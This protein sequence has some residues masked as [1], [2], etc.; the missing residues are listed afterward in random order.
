[1]MNCVRTPALCLLALFGVMAMAAHADFPTLEVVPPDSSVHPGQQATFIYRVSWAGDGNEWRVPA[2][3]MDQPL[4]GRTTLQSAT[5]Y[6]EGG[7]TVVDFALGI[8]AGDTG[9][10]ELPA[11]E[12]E[13][14]PSSDIIKNEKA[15][16]KEPPEPWRT[17]LILTAEPVTLEVVPD[18]GRWIPTG[19]VGGLTV[20]VMAGALWAVFRSRPEPAASQPVSDDPRDFIHTARKHRLDGDFYRFFQALAGAAGKVKGPE[21]AKLAAQHNE[22]AREVG[23]GGIRPTDDEMDAALKDTERLIAAHRG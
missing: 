15:P 17:D 3:A 16:L 19:I 20:L 10:F 5:T 6:S 4:W 11:V 8:V 1:M 18:Y 21:A 23:Y 22:R 7:R 12:F 13:V 9:R 2:P 14:F